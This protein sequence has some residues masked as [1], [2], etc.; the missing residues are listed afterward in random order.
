MRML[1]DIQADILVLDMES[2]GVLAEMLD[3]LAT[4]IGVRNDDR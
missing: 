4:S 3:C 2:E 1:E